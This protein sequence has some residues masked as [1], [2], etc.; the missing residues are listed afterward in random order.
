MQIPRGALRRQW[1]VQ[2]KTCSFCAVKI[3]FDNDLLEIGHEGMK[4]GSTEGRHQGRKEEGRKDGR[5]KGRGEGRK[6]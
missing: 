4:V 5:K 6:E 3:V 2:S 1:D